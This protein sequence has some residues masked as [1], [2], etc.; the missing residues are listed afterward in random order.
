MKVNQVNSL[1]PLLRTDG[2]PAFDEAWQAQALAMA[3][4][5]TKTNMFSPNDWSA[6]LGEQL[7][8]ADENGEPDT[9]HT[10]YECVLRALESLVVLS[11]E[12]RSKEI[13]NEQKAWEEAYR[14][15]PHGE[16]V[17]LNRHSK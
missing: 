4:T 8:L 9:Q 12:V 1:V 10:Y 13:Q 3:D 16:P 17:K 2:E 14:A 7:K 11:G 15:T 5:L 6:A